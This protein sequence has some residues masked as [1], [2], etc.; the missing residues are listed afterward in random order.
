MTA[1]NDYMINVHGQLLSLQKPVVMGIL[2]CTPDSFFAGSRK[3]TEVEIAERT[4]QIINE[5]GSI[6]DVGAFS[7]RPGAQEV[8]EEE[9]M[10]RLR[11]A[12]AIVR[13]ES[14]SS[15]VSVDT[16]RP[17][18]ARMAV[19][20][21][22]VDIINDVSEGGITGIVDTPLESSKERE[23]PEIFQMMGKLK[24][25]YIL[26]SVQGNLHDMIYRFSRE[27]EQLHELQVKDIILDPGFGFGKT[28]EANYQILNEM[29]KLEIFGLPVL[30]GVSRKRM[31]HQLI[32]VPADEA[33][34]GTTVV[35]TMALMKGAKILRVHDVLEASQAVTIYNQLISS[36]QV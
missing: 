32:Q 15:I 19:E 18:V 24:V 12:L 7:T 35:D 1:Q 30:A 5:G 8:S 17:N 34:N 31:I 14:P 28:I 29:D 10:R 6:I 2:N 33:L 13:R 3:Q 36:S 22:G 16:Y 9:E 4:W 27:I 11:F 20:E 21:Y 26:M 25:P 23:Y